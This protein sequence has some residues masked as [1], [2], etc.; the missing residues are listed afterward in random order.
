MWYYSSVGLTL[1]I[2]YISSFP[3]YLNQW[4]TLNKLRLEQNVNYAPFCSQELDLRLLPA[5]S[6]K[7]KLFEW[8][9]SGN[10][11]SKEPI[12]FVQQVELDD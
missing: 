5:M 1:Y 11:W 6:V 12:Q 10:Y 3:F 7:N 8:E 4:C 9:P 2:L